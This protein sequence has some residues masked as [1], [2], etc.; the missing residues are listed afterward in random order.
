MCHIWFMEIQGFLYTRRGG[1]GGGG[2]GKLD[3]TMW[4]RLA[5]GIPWSL[6]PECCEYRSYSVFT[7]FQDEPLPT[8]ICFIRIFSL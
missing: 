3:L 2:G 4:L 6:I 8:K 5:Q 7:V 1:G